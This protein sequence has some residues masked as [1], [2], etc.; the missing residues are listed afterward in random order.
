M[1]W[2]H[3]EE[4]RYSTYIRNMHN[5]TKIRSV[6]QW[7]GKNDGNAKCRKW[8]SSTWATICIYTLF[9]RQSSV[10]IPIKE[11]S[12]AG[13][14]R[15]VSTTSSTILSSIYTFKKPYIQGSVISGYL[16]KLTCLEEKRE[17]NHFK[18]VDNILPTNIP[19]LKSSSPPQ[20]LFLG[21][22]SLMCL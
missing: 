7:H 14:A 6:Q 5:L 1:L 3:I 21:C 19:K 8:A 18:C 17:W 9:G 22:T 4:T 11:M 13:V 2:T 10:W 12:L 16:K 15:F 20:H